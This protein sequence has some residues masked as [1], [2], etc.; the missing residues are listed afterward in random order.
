MDK[1]SKIAEKLRAANEGVITTRVKRKDIKVIGSIPVAKGATTELTECSLVEVDG[2]YVLLHHVKNVMP[3]SKDWRIEGNVGHGLRFMW[4]KINSLPHL[5]ILVEAFSM[6]GKY[7]RH[8]LTG[9]TFLIAYC[10]A[11]GLDL[12]EL[13]FIDR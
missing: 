9:Y 2:V 7:N 12:V 1:F 4:F 5:E 11:N 13:G 6:W 8:S 3:L 10:L